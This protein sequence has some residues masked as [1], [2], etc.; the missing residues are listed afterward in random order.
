MHRK[1]RF[2]E[3][4]SI[5]HKSHLVGPRWKYQRK[6]RAF[7]T[8]AA[9]LS[10]DAHHKKDL[11]RRICLEGEVGGDTMNWSTNH[12]PLR[13]VVF[14]LFC[15]PDGATRGFTSALG[16]PLRKLLLNQE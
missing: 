11:L 8:M 3:G 10:T 16:L 1:S 2:L 12:G 6:E 9:R 13:Q 15:T 7:T 14:I 4:M 5:N